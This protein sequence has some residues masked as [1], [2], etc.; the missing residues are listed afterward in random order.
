[1]FAQ[2]IRKGA[3]NVEQHYYECDYGEAREMLF[4]IM[5]VLNKL[6]GFYTIASDEGRYRKEI[7]TM[8]EESSIAKTGTIST[9]KNLDVGLLEAIFD[10]LASTNATYMNFT[11]NLRLSVFKNSDTCN[12]SEF[13]IS[14]N[15]LTQRA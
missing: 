3:Y 1:M 14:A 11:F 7:L 9:V 2:N 8:L 15:E 5:R 12:L 13:P 10:E 6:A 4:R